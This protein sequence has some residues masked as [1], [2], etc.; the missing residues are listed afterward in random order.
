MTALSDV[1]I[2][3]IR[4]LNLGCGTDIQPSTNE[5][6]WMHL[7]SAPLAGVDVVHNLT[8]F[9]WP[10][11]NDTLDEIKAHDILEHLPDAVWTW[12]RSGRS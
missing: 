6:V 3:P 7:D 1:M 11:E 4:K 10:L 5:V 9:P 12:R 8:E 2:E